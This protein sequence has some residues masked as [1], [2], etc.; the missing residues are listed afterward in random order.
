MLL[1]GE[2]SAEEYSADPAPLF[3]RLRLG[4]RQW[5]RTR[6]FWGGL[7]LLLSGLEYYVSAHMDL[8]P[9]KVSFGSE[10]FLSWVIPL[11]IVLCGVLT[12]LTPAQ[13][14]FYGIVGAVVAVAGLI[15]LNLGGF[16]VGMLLGIAGGALAVAWV[17]V[18]PPPR[19]IDDTDEIEPIGGTDEIEP[20]GGRH[21]AEGDDPPAPRL[22]AMLLLVGAVTAA[23]LAL[24][25]PTPAAA[26]PCPKPPGG[27]APKPAPSAS[28]STSTSPS[29]S[30]SPSDTGGN[31]VSDFFNG[32]GKLLGITHDSAATA[33]PSP[34][35]TPTP[36]P[37]KSGPV[38]KPSPAASCS[39]PPG[40][41]P[42]KP[43]N[44]AVPAGQPLVNKTP[45]TQISA[46]LT[47]TLVS[48]DGVVDL[49]TH[50]GT[51]R[52]LQFTLGSAESK[53]FEL[54]V[55]TANGTLS[56]KSSDLKISGHVRFY[57]SRIHGRL[58]GIPPAIDFTPDGLQPPPIPLPIIFFTEAE[59]D[60]VFVQ[61]DRLTAPN[62][63]IGY[64]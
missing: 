57:A 3:T 16:F 10:G 51:I 35:P 55:P 54:R 44:L 20:I 43:R 15:G 24:P 2:G 21:A 30:P 26:A 4:F 46:V 17:P 56:L 25:H 12:W 39:A 49:P 7:F 6:P 47:E 1:N 22:G 13:R 34:S 5:R 63:T 48:F 32:L 45:S 42:G 19:A 59:V 52:A 53:P 14:M 33:S 58:L 29:P 38:T 62:L 9:V 64:L 23:L 11:S 31:P 37:T 8:M 60:L 27:T 28:P 36:S 61:A 40:K 41:V 18:G 50:D